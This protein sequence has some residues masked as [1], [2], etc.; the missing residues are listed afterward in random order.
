MSTTRLAAIATFAAAAVLLAASLLYG[1]IIGAADPGAMEAMS[2]DMDTVGNSATSLGPRDECIVAS[3][4]STITLDVTAAS[5]PVAY[6]MLAFT[7]TL[8]F[9][10]GVITVESANPNFLLASTPGSSLFDVS[11]PV[12]DA[13]GI[14]YS[15]VVDVSDSSIVPSESGSGVLDRITLSVA[16]GAPAGVYLLALSEAGHVDP[17]STGHGPAAIHN[18]FLAVGTTCDV[19]P[20]V[21]PLP[22]DD[23]G[24]A[25][26]IVALPF[27]D[28][29]ATNEASTEAGEQP[30]AG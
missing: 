28:S 27:N 2:I 20:T 22:N 30:L 23:F 3:P 15:A 1:R 9:P 19:L 21:A 8:N 29:V 11:D 5:V 24:F 14:W 7:F 26:P 18:A 10:A 13:D 4:G 17:T 25:T 6:P 12:P 16:P